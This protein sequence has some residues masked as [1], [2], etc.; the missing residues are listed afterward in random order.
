MHQYTG[1]DYVFHN[2]I[3]K[4]TADSQ[5]TV[6]VQGKHDFASLFYSLV[7]LQSFV[8]QKYIIAWYN[9]SRNNLVRKRNAYLRKNK[10]TIQ[11]LLGVYDKYLK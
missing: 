10:T 2:E 9:C 1:G 4:Q 7:A 6:K 8:N 3:V 11:D 5:T